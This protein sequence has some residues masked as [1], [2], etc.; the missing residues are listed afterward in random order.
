MILPFVFALV[1]A[2]DPV[3]STATFSVKHIFV[4]HVMGTI[5]IAS[6]VIRFCHGNDVPTDMYA[7]LDAAGVK[8]DKPD[9]DAALRG[10]EFFDTARY[11]RWTFASTRVAPVPGGFSVW[12]LLTI[13]GVTQPEFLSV[14]TIGSKTKPHYRATA[15]IDRHAFGMARSRL[16]PVIGSHVEVTLDIAVQDGGGV[17]REGGIRTHTSCPGRF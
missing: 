7:T 3:H 9:R 12:G 10:P 11:P 14:V 5:P 2:I 4:S 15:Q 16:D 8:T 6:G 1:L 17:H 13:H